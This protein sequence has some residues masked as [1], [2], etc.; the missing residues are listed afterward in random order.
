MILFTL[1][2]HLSPT[3]PP[4]LTSPHL[5]SPQSPQCILSSSASKRSPFPIPLSLVI[6]LFPFASC[7]LPT[8]Y[9]LTCGQKFSL[10]HWN[11][12]AVNGDDR[13]R[14][15]SCGHHLNSLLLPPF[16]HPIPIIPPAGTWAH[17]VMFA[18]KFSH[19]LVLLRQ[20]LQSALNFFRANVMQR[21]ETAPTRETAAYHRVEIALNTVRVV[22]VALPV[23]RLHLG[24]RENSHGTFASLDV[25][26]V[27]Y[28]W[29][30]VCYTSGILWMSVSFL[31]FWNLWLEIKNH[32]WLLCI[33][34]KCLPY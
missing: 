20:Q 13:R 23:L 22:S 27:R 32:L 3:H 10:N 14:N 19:R 34:K 28:L 8:S 30:S 21:R 26:Q 17:P 7:I 2:A 15:S 31:L 6:S 29:L 1:P 33:Q 5:T 4:H 11:L 12:S 16:P 9:H 18:G 24:C 25:I